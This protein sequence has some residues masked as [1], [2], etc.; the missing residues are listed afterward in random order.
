MKRPAPLTAALAALAILATFAIGLIVG[1]EITRKPAAAQAAAAGDE[2]GWSPV[3]RELLQYR[4]RLR[5]PLPMEQPR[6]FAVGLDGALLVCGDRSLVVVDRSGTSKAR[7]AL[8]GAPRCVAVDGK[9]RVYVGM[10]DHVVAL[11]PASGAMA[12]W[13]DLGSQ[14][15]I[16]SIAA[17]GS[18]V[19]VAD[20][21]NQM[22][23]CF[24]TGGKLLSIVDRGFNLPSPFL[25]V[26]TSPDGTIW[27]TNSGAHRVLRYSADGRP[28]GGW[29]EASALIDGFIGCCNPVHLAVL[30]CGSIVTS[31]KGVPRVKVYEPGGRLEAVVAGP[32]DFPPGTTTLAV[33]TRKAHGGEVLVLVP[34]ERAIRVYCHSE[35]GG[36]D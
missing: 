22:L 34:A 7:W 4:L 17:A 5:I 9:G 24:D 23:L 20:A 1:M 2:A 32:R 35:E 16:T 3:P 25:D 12:S 8:E 36:D 14:A 31:E 6:G 15:I 27:A 21:G 10:E 19:F 26:G 29:G 13:P 30:P 33:A 28:A 11:N 18:K